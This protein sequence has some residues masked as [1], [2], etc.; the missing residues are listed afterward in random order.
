MLL[1]FAELY[2]IEGVSAI[3]LNDFRQ[4]FVPKASFDSVYRNT[5]TLID[6]GVI[7]KVSDLTTRAISFQVADET[8]LAKRVTDLSEDIDFEKAEQV[9]A[10]AGA[11]LSAEDVAPIA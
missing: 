5:E 11:I 7:R 8:Q 9:R 1:G 2:F 10:A 6:L 3:S 4:R